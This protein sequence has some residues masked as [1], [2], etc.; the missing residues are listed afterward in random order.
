MAG[1]R[2]AGQL[3]TWPITVWV[4]RILAPADYPLTAFRVK[5]S[6]LIDATV[7]ALLGLGTEV[8]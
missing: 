2:F 6:F 7:R 8:P 5:N 1:G 3:V 4:M